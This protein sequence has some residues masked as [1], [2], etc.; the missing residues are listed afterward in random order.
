MYPSPLIVYKHILTF[1]NK[2]DPFLNAFI[3]KP[4]IHKYNLLTVIL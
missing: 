4:G 2:L 1:H 3:L